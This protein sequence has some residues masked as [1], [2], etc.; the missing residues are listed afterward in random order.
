MCPS[1]FIPVVSRETDTLS[2]SLILFLSQTD[3]NAATGLE[4]EIFVGASKFDNVDS[5]HY[6]ALDWIL[7]KDAMQLTTEA[8]N[9][10]QRYTLALFYFRTSVEIPW[11]SCNPPTEN[12]TAQCSHQRPI[13]FWPEM[14][15]EEEPGSIRWLSD[16]HECECE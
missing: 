5:P 1:L 7:H 6:K 3:K 2:H 8:E 14:V 12:Q 9:L 13:V 16:K 4:H 10:F 11:L 15:Y